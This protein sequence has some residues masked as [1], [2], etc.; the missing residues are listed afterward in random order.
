MRTAFLPP[1]VVL[2]VA[3]FG[4]CS[5][6]K[7]PADSAPTG[8]FGDDG[9][10]PPG[11]TP[12]DPPAAD[13]DAG[14]PTPAGEGASTSDDSGVGA[15]G[16][17]A[18]P[19]LEGSS[20]APP[21]GPPFDAGEAGVCG[22]PPGAGDLIVTELMIE[23]V[24]GAGD[25][26]EWLEVASTVGCA[27][28][29]RGLQGSAP[30]A[31]KVRTFDIADDLW[32]AGYGTFVVADSSN[33]AINHSLPGTV[34]TW[35]GQPGDVLRNKGG[36]VTLERAGTLVDSVTYPSMALVAGVSVAF[37]SD[38]PAGRRPDWTAWQPS[39]GSWFPG[40]FGTPNAPNDDVSCSVPSP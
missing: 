6:A 3:L 28:D 18:A 13:G 19:V 14:V 7:L 11:P 5:P 2:S 10:P 40:F 31:G 16:L 24:A 25:H 23:S 21:A 4:G 36:T 9:A 33:S 34:V 39:V 27:L 38:C 26:G 32:L 12:T 17:D 37:P 20:P 15:V 22:A 29:L 1:S 30:T 8:D 35:S